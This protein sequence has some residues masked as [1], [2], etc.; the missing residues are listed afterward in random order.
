MVGHFGKLDLEVLRKYGLQFIRIQQHELDLTYRF[1]N[2]F[3]LI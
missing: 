2:N 3:Y 1:H